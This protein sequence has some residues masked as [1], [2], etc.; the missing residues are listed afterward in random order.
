MYPDSEEKDLWTAQLE[1]LRY[2]ARA[3]GPGVSRET[4]TGKEVTTKA[5]VL[6]K[7]EPAYTE[8]ARSQG[9]TGTVVLRCIFGGDGAVKHFVIIRAL[10][11]GLTEASIRA[12]KKIRFIPATLNGNPVSMFIQLEYNFN[13]Y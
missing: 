7:P 11:H 4:Y 5:R 8:R 2:H 1:A 9:V 13:L 6:S 3:G 12:A 10:P